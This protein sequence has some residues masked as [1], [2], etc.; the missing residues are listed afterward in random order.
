MPCALAGQGAVS[1]THTEKHYGKRTRSRA[2]TDGHAQRARKRTRRVEAPHRKPR[3]DLGEQSGNVGRSYAA[4]R[5]RIG[6]IRQTARAVNYDSRPRWLPDTRTVSRLAGRYPQEFRAICVRPFP[7]E[8]AAAVTE[9]AA[10]SDI[11]D[12][13]PFSPVARG[14]NLCIETREGLASIPWALLDSDAAMKEHAEKMAR[15]CSW[16]GD[17]DGMARIC[18]G[19]QIDPPDEK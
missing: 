11:A 13:H 16:S 10:A 5:K 14:N 7:P 15:R 1:P 19:A 3:R 4:S 9:R 2:R 8:L 17:V 12:P 6:R 18:V